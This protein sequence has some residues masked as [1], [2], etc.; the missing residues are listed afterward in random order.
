MKDQ[1]FSENIPVVEYFSLITQ[2]TSSI[3]TRNSI[4]HKGR[5]SLT[6]GQAIFYK[7]GRLKIRTF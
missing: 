2:Y 6:G 7:V 4:G 5:F 3:E 1:A